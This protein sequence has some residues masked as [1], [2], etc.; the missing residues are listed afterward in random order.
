[1]SACKG[2]KQTPT[3]CDLWSFTASK[4][5][6]IVWGLVGHGL[7]TPLSVEEE[8]V[9]SLP[10]KVKA[11]NQQHPQTLALFSWPQLIWDGPT[12]SGKVCRGLT[13]P[14]FG[15]LREIKAVASTLSC[16]SR[17]VPSYSS[18]TMKPHSAGVTTA[19]LWSK[20]VQ[21]LDWCIYGKEVSSV[22]K[23]LLSVVKG[24]GDVTHD[25]VLMFWKVLQAS[26]NK[27]D[28]F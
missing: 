5:N 23:G 20:R 2:Q 14:H 28:Q 1:M 17:N 18:T 13:S 15:L 12:Q 24:Q 10:C 7:R 6:V 21:I 25:P 22:P 8:E 16:F 26:T 11:I 27:V 9:K 4:I 3:P 19:W